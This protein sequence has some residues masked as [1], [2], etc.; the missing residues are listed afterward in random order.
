[1]MDLILFSGQS[2]M[3]GQSEELRPFP[4]PKAWEYRWLQDALVPLCD[5][6]GEDIRYDR[7]AGHPFD[8]TDQGKWLEA[9][10]TGSACYG[11]TSL[12]PA[13]CA[14]Y[15]AV[16]GREAVAAHIAK[17]STQIA[18]WLP[19]TAGFEFLLKKASAAQR[20]TKAEHT[21]FVWLQ[22]ESDALA[23]NGK[24]YYLE[25]LLI[26]EQALRN[27]L[28]IELFGIIRVGRFTGD[29]RDDAIIDAQREACRRRGFL[30][31][32]EQ[33]ETAPLNP[34]VKGHFSA[35]GLQQIG[36][37][38]GKSLGEYRNFDE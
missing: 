35:A 9:H 14:G 6:V 38:A 12:V 2:N 27:E 28:K 34:K 23:G 26:L 10:L 22:G 5:P 3:Q 11:H 20:A 24:D 19:A 25:K 30:M 16:S 13:F 31:L 15:T 21:Y 4:A 18:D 33:T 36:L 37:D 29:G 17:G 1:M 7:T 32:S 8:G